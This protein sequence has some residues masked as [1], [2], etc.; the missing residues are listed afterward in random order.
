M[1]AIGQTLR[2]DTIIATKVQRINDASVD[3]STDEVFFGSGNKLD[4]E[5]QCQLDY[6]L[7][8]MYPA[9]AGTNEVGIVSLLSSQTTSNMLTIMN[10]IFLLLRR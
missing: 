5:A 9:R 6:G 4:G 10:P 7:I 3:R 1:I 8:E 2:A